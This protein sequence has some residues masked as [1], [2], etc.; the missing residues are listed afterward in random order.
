ML[1]MINNPSKPEWA[2]PKILGALYRCWRTTKELTASSA[3]QIWQRLAR[4]A[5]WNERTRHQLPVRVYSL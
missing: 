3:L 1:Q 2:Q 5:A 4:S